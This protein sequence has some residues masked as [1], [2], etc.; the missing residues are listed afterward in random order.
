MGDLIENIADSVA[1]QVTN[2]HHF[3]KNTNI[4]I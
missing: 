1:D 4:S 3:Q 2:I